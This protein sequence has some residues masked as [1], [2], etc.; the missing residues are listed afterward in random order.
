MISDDAEADP[1]VHAVEAMVATAAQAVTTREHTD[2]T[3]APDAPALPAAEPALT[4]MGAPRR[5]LGAGPRQ[6]HPSHAAVHRR[7]FVAG[8]AETA[9]AR[10]QIRRAPEDRLRPIQRRGP[11]RDVGRPSRMNFEGGH[12]LMSWPAAGCRYYSITYA[13][14][15]SP[16]SRLELAGLAALDDPRQHHADGEDHEDVDKTAHRDRTDRSQEPEHD[17]D[18]REGCHSAQFLWHDQELE[19]LDALFGLPP[20]RSRLRGNVALARPFGPR[21][22]PIQR[23]D[24][25]AK[26]RN[27]RRPFLISRH[28]RTIL[29]PSRHACAVRDS[30]QPP[31]GIT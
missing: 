27:D 4:F 18:Q 12:D 5:R 8:R 16:R 2:A 17:E 13:V 6:D 14:I 23:G 11:Q 25:L 3:F 26:S 9:V 29:D 10:G 30:V 22:P 7:L 1:S 31:S 28:I 15:S 20:Q 19:L 24:Q 21:C